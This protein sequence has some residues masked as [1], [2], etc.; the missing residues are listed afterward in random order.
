MITTNHAA[1]RLLLSVV[2]VLLFGFTVLEASAAE[3]PADQ[4]ATATVPQT[5]RG[6]CERRSMTHLRNGLSARA[7]CIRSA[8]IQ[9]D[10][11]TF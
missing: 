6:A 3:R 1:R 2:A 5:N 7:R 11:E 8:V 10:G 9:A 4:E